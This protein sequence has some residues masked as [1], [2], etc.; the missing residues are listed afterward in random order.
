MLARLAPARREA[1]FTRAH[2]LAWSRELL[3]VHYPSDSEAGRVLAEDFV[4]FLF[5]S[6]AFVRDFEAV[7]DEWVRQSS[8]R[9][10]GTAAS[11]VDDAGQTAGRTNTGPPRVSRN[12]KV[13]VACAQTVVPVSH[14]S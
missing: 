9:H 2:E 10:R 13:T 14:T 3:G 8:G 1:L 6:P 5:E 12:Q 4:R 7:R 11:R